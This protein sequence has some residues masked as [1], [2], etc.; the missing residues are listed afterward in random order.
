MLGNII[1]AEKT[2]A[3]ILK[4]FRDSVREGIT[5]TI[6]QSLHNLVY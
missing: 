2:N 4:A 3:S 1:V 5:I 6:H